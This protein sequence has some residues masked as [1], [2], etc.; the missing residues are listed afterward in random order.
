V[1]FRKKLWDRTTK[2]IVLKEELHKF[3]IPAGKRSGNRSIQ[4]IVIGK[5]ALQMSQSPNV[6]WDN[7]MKLIVR[8]IEFVQVCC[9]T[10]IFW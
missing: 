6:T 10:Q 3:A 1:H 7:T 2:L 5:E 4:V 9:E 8:N